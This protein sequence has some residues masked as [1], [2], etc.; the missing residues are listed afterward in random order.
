MAKVTLTEIQNLQSETTAVQAINAN[1]QELADAIENTLS[2]DGT[3]PNSLSANLDINSNRILNLPEPVDDTEPVRLVDIGGIAGLDLDTVATLAA[4]VSAD[5]DA[6]AASAA[7]AAGYVGSAVQAP[8]WTT[9]RTI[10][11]SGDLTGTSPAWDGSANLTWTGTVIAAGAVTATKLG[12]GAVVTHLG[13]TPA[14]LSGATFTGDCRLNFTAASL[15]TDSV[16]FRGVP[17]NSQNGV[18]SFVINDVGR[19]VRHADSTARAW[20]ID[21]VATTA[22]P[23]GAA[24]VVRNVG[25]GIITLT[26]GSGVA[27]RKAGSATDAN[28]AVAQWGMA[29][30][31]HEATDVWVVTGTGIS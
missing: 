14:S 5:A 18:Y 19:M 28:I 10:T 9:A 16:G 27:L 4:Q 12:A 23:V 22:F 15:S 24:I 6:A 7:E 13:Y 8:K 26:R 29:T 1:F 31:I 21:P 11:V 3:T 17:I 25:S 30:L 2:R 20:T